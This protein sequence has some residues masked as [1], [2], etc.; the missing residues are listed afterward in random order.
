[1]KPT[2]LL[3]WLLAIIASVLFGKSWTPFVRLFLLLAVP[4]TLG[5]AVAIVSLLQLR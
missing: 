1:M 2:T 3:T 5:L 4:V